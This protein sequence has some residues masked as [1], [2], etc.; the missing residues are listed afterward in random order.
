M[1]SKE[2]T[3]EQKAREAAYQKQYQQDHKAELAI[4]KK[5]YRQ[6]HKLEI[7]AYNKQYRQGHEFERAIYRK[8]RK[9]IDI[10][11]KLKS[12]F[13]SE[14][15]QSIKGAKQYK[16][17]TDL[18]GC[19]IPEV[20]KHLE[21]QFQSGMTWGNWSLHGWHIDHVIPLASFDFNDPEQQ[22]RAWH[23]TNLRPLWAEENMR[24]RAKIIE[25]QLV[26]L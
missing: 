1:M 4:Y 24:K 9:A 19:T 14:I 23:Y 12:K 22:K 7:A 8:G 18:L 20:R 26:L 16:H 25:I 2:L 15:K 10:D 21:R 13:S 3:I 17:S 5:Q 11:F 6:N